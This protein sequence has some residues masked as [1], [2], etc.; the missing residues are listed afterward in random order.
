MMINRR[1][2]IAS[3]TVVVVTPTLQLLPSQQPFSVSSQNRVSFLIH[4]WN[5]SDDG[6]AADQVWIKISNSWRTAWR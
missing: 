5:D 6:R 4:G 2:F 3:A 1:E